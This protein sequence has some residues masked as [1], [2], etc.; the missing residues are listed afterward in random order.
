MKAILINPIEQTITAVEHEG[1]LQ[2]I[3]NLLNCQTVDVARFD[4]PH[5]DAIY[6]DDEGLY[7]NEYFFFVE[8]YYTPLAGLGLVV[9]LDWEGGDAA[10]VTTLDEI[11]QKV[12][13][14]TRAQALAYFRKLEERVV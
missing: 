11:K 1:N 4:N 14:L 9:G 5:R 10:P 7:V 13:F 12:K 8:G 2:S 3:R 6:V